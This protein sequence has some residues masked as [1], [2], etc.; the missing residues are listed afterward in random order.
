MLVMERFVHL[1]YIPIIVQ[2]AESHLVVYA[3]GIPEIAN[4]NLDFEF[5]TMSMI[6]RKINS[7]ISMSTELNATQ[8]YTF[9]IWMVTKN[10]F[11][12]ILT[13]NM[14]KMFGRTIFMRL[15]TI[16]TRKR[17]RDAAIFGK[18]EIFSSIS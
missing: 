9:Y 10:V 17:C 5:G 6:R 7:G 1:A 3:H 14:R 8:R 13:Q 2:L 12:Q 16:L 18:K 4:G 15:M 11:A